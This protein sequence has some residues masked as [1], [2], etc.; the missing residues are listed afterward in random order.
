VGRVL[1]GTAMSRR[2]LLLG[3]LAALAASLAACGKKG[4]LKRKDEAEEAD[5]Q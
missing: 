2:W 4:P 3:G 1:L 5:K